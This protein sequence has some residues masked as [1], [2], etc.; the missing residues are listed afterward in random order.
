[1]PSLL[2]L[3]E[4]ILLK[5]QVQV[6]QLTNGTKPQLCPEPSSVVNYSL[7]HASGPQAT[8]ITSENRTSNP[9]RCRFFGCTKGARGALDFALDMVVDRDVRNQDATK[10][11][12]AELL[13]VRPMVEGRGA[14]T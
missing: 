4:W 12:R 14:N 6:Q 11:L 1:M 3:L 2:W 5:V 7:D 10:V 9:K 13:I 8:G